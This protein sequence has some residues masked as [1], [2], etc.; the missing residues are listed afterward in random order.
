LLY[1][2]ERRKMMDDFNIIIVS[3]HGMTYSKKIVYLDEFVS[4]FLSRV[5]Y[6]QWNPRSAFPSVS[7]NLQPRNLEDTQKILMEL[8][9]SE[10][11]DCYDKKNVPKDWHIENTV[12]TAEIFCVGKLGNLMNLNRNA[13]NLV[14]PGNHG[15]DHNE[16]DMRSIFFAFGPSIKHEE[17]KSFENVEIYNLMTKL[18][19]IEHHAAPNNGTI[20]WTKYLKK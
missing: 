9:V 16:V 15:F 3:D 2:L 17:M 5:D 1:G 6:Y 4:D 8:K 11:I 7:V 18:L 14:S 20:D 12:R 10:D 13:T 19:N